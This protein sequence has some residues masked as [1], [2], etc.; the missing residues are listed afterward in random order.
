MRIGRGK[1]RGA[2]ALEISG[3]Q[4]TAHG[5]TVSADSGRRPRFAKLAHISRRQKLI[6]I[7]AVLVVVGA[8]I[9]LLW[10]AKPAP[11]DSA[12]QKSKKKLL[13]LS[14]KS[15]NLAASNKP[16]DSIPDIEAYLATPNLPDDLKK[17]ALTQLATAYQ[18]AKQ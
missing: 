3:Q 11:D 13:A 12:Y 15:T 1:K 16:A 17:D 18:H 2:G 5:A 6:A 4:Q 14:E 7:A 10:P 9:V 8:A